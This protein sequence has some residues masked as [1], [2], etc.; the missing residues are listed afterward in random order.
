MAGTECSGHG[1]IVADLPSCCQEKTVTKGR[2]A[3]GDLKVDSRPLRAERVPEG[4]GW[5]RG[6]VR[7]RYGTIATRP[8]WRGRQ[9]GVARTLLRMSA[10][11]GTRFQPYRFPGHNPSAD[12]S[13]SAYI[14]IDVC[15]T[16]AYPSAASP[17][18]KSWRNSSEDFRSSSQLAKRSGVSSHTRN[19]REISS[20]SWRFDSRTR[21]FAARRWARNLPFFTNAR[22][23]LTPSGSAAPL[24][25]RKISSSFCK[26]RSALGRS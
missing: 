19:Q 5:V 4:R 1:G 13:N 3:G 7:Y 6:L 24:Y 8:P 18:P 26:D 11:W 9:S 10:T 15:A 17:P 23:N 12:G 2:D 25:S 22:T 16:R 20:F 21:G 14:K